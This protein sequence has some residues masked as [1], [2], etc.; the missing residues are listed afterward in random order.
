MFSVEEGYLQLTRYLSNGKSVVMY[1]ARAG[2]TFT[3]AALFA[4]VYHCNGIAEVKNRVCLYRRDPVNML[5]RRT[6]EGPL[7]AVCSPSHEAPTHNAKPNPKPRAGLGAS[8]E[9][10]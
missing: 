10:L 1:V 5:L 6:C 8:L 2:G 7:L 9:P 4:E 3:E